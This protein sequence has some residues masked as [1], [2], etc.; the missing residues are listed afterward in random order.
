[1]DI[2]T[3]KFKKKYIKKD[4]TK[5]KKNQNKPTRNKKFDNCSQQKNSRKGTTKKSPKLEGKVSKFITFP[6]EFAK[7]L[8]EENGINGRRKRKRYKRKKN[9]NKKR[10]KKSKKERREERRKKTNA[11]KLPILQTNI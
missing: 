6:E 5:C 1:M 4:P 2:N 7:W 9:K 8:K 3:D 10:E 11:Q